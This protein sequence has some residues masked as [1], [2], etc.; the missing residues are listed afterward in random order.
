M[1]PAKYKRDVVQRAEKSL[2]EASNNFPV[3][4]DCDVAYYSAGSLVRSQPQLQKL[5]QSRH[6]I[7][8]TTLTLLMS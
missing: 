1:Y 7:P 3:H 5:I 2:T 6:P 4:C 8:M